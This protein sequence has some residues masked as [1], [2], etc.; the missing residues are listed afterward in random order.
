M[1]T[2]ALQGGSVMKSTSAVLD[3]VW[4]SVAVTCPLG[5]YRLLI[6]LFDFL[7]VFADQSAS[8]VW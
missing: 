5:P 2:R 3:G 7:S 8:L 6:D 1:F 4:G